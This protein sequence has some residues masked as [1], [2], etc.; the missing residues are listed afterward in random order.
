VATRRSVR[1]HGRISPLDIYLSLGRRRPR[2][3][4][5]TKP[6]IDHREP[7]GRKRKPLPVNNSHMTTSSGLRER[8]TSLGELRADGIDLSAA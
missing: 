3:K 2:N 6:V 7:A 8:K 4:P 5:E 1:L